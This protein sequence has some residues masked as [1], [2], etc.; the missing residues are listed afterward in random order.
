M[1]ILYKC[2]QLKNVYVHLPFCTK[3]CHFCAF[4]VHAVGN[5]K[6][7]FNNYLQHLEK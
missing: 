2:S 5:D 4:P 7:L 6:S 3:K 1:D